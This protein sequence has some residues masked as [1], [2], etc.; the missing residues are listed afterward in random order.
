MVEQTP[1]ASGSQTAAYRLAVYDCAPVETVPAKHWT[2]L[3]EAE[4]ESH[5]KSRPRL[6]HLIRAAICAGSAMS[7]VLLAIFFSETAS[8]RTIGKALIAAVILTVLMAVE[9]FRAWR[10]T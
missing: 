9:L 5:L 10:A 4:R 6:R 7:L 1:S 8:G 2:E 3:P